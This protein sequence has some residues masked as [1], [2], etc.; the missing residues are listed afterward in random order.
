MS[1]RIR[2]S[3]IISILAALVSGCTTSAVDSEFPVPVVDK[4]PIKVAVYF[5]E[6]FS[7]FAYRE[8]AV[9]EKS[10]VIM[11][12]S[13]NVEM[14]RR[15]FQGMF[16]ETVELP[17]VPD[18]KFP[19]DQ[20]DAVIAP[21]VESFEIR[22]PQPPQYTPD[23]TQLLRG[24]DETTDRFTVW[25]TYRMKMYDSQGRPIASWPIRAYGQT[26]EGV[27]DMFGPDEAL[28]RATTIAMRD[29]G[30][31]LSIYFED[32]PSVREWIREEGI[33]NRPPPRKRG[34]AIRAR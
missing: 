24:V 8:Q 12:G 16:R 14:M 11:I 19:V 25:I 21:E 34:K 23:G 15:A 7:N 27:M 18:L 10:W 6:S 4:L 20:V 29:A 22:T 30:A 33:E 32:E 9:G 31:Y 13:A 17:D 28:A 26:P 1:K 5:D 3:A 2:H